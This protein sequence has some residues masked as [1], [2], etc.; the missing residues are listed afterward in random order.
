MSNS[1]RPVD[2]LDVFE[3]PKVQPSKFLDLLLEGFHIDPVEE[4][5]DL[6]AKPHKYISDVY[7]DHIFVSYDPFFLF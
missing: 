4:Q 7:I 3:K 6:L 1:Y 5:R 2:K